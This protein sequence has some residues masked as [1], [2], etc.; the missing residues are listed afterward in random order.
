[1]TSC[2]STPRVEILRE[3]G[4]SIHSFIHSSSRAIDDVRALQLR[5]VLSTPA[6]STIMTSMHLEELPYEVVVEVVR[7]LDAPALAALGATSRWWRQVARSD[8]VWRPMLHCHRLR[9]RSPLWLPI[10]AALGCRALIGSADDSVALECATSGAGVQCV[11]ASLTVGD[12]SAAP[13]QAS[14]LIDQYRV[15]YET[16]LPFARV[17]SAL[18]HG[19]RAHMPGGSSHGWRAVELHST[20]TTAYVEDAAFRILPSSRHS[21]YR[22]TTNLLAV[23]ASVVLGLFWSLDQP[24][25]ALWDSSGMSS[26][27]SASAP[28]WNSH[29]WLCLCVCVSKLE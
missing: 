28:L 11:P 25:R 19:L 9:A 8:L 16:L 4:S 18:F 23:P 2:I 6:P 17:L 20:T 27:S 15:R 14:C 22:Y 12:T 7:W 21:A 1:M 3:R 5:A 13:S 24:T 10:E 26:S 29:P